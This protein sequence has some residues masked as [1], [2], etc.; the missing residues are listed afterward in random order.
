[1]PPPMLGALVAA[2]C[3]ACGAR[4]SPA[5]VLLRHVGSR[6]VQSSGQPGGCHRPTHEW[7]AR[8]AWFACTQGGIFLTHVF[9][10]LL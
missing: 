4:P 8:P 9:A 6:A 2:L 3:R 7:H 1:M 10:A 5:P